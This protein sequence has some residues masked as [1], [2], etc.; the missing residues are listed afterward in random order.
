MSEDLLRP[1]AE[2]RFKVE[3]AGTKRVEVRLSDGCDDG[4]GNFHFRFAST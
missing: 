3:S 1:R 2:D 4:A